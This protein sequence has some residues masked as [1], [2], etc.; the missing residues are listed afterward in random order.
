MGVPLRIRQSLSISLAVFAAVEVIM[1][2]H[3]LL[4]GPV[5]TQSGPVALTGLSL[6][7]TFATAIIAA[8]AALWMIEPMQ[9]PV[10]RLR[11]ASISTV[12]AYAAVL[13]GLVPLLTPFLLPNFLF[14]HDGG[15][16]QTYAYLFDRAVHQGQL[17]VRWVEGLGYGRGQPLFNYYQVGFYYLV[18]L[19]HLLGPRLSISVK[20]AIAAVWAAGTC[21]T[22]LWLRPLGRL[23]GLL[24]AAV[25]AW[26]PYLMVDG[27]VRTAYPEL[28]AVCLIPAVFW[29]LDR[30][31]RTGR[32]LFVGALALAIALLIISHLPA[33]LIVA[34]ICGAY[35]LARSV[36]RPVNMRHSLLTVMAVGVGIGLSAFYTLPSILE[37]DAVRIRG[38]TNN[39]LDFH[40]HFVRP[41]AWLDWAWGYAP[42][43]SGEA[44]QISTQI[45]IV[46]WIVVAAAAVAGVS[47]SS[48]RDPKR[49]AL[50]GWLAVVVYALFMM[51]AASVGIWNRIAPLAF[52]QFPWRFL[53]VPTVAC[54]AL[55]A[56]VLTFVPNRT[57]QALIVICA[58][59]LQWS[60]T[61]TYWGQAW[62]RERAAIA[63]DGPG[64]WISRN[65]S[66]WGFREAAYDPKG[67]TRTP[68]M[69]TERWT[70]VGGRSDV[71]PLLLT[72]TRV[73]L[74]V[75][76]SE[77]TAV[78][79]RSPFF[80]GW[81]LSLDG[82]RV[83]PRLQPDT[84]YM[85]VDV[86]PGSHRVDA[87][88]GNTRLRTTANRV[89][90]ASLLLWLGIVGW[91]L[92]GDARSSSRPFETL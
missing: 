23:P 14:A 28:M 10:N 7:T 41:A 74:R 66:M 32:P 53:M 91:S 27:Y 69:A 13:A 43:A 44:G 57:T 40:R 45:G 65:A 59:A 4:V 85:E 60:V 42:S 80:P 38:L 58:V 77:P 68:P 67:V 64:W 11:I 31:L 89:S 81:Q 46:Q 71:T 75:A 88:F 9:S 73:E 79:V 26:S 76:A 12:F 72:D 56:L 63:I 1:A 29:S 84:A 5:A 24:A 61:Q 36:V 47:V 17:P 33:A 8:G 83:T 34:P 20:L 62:V 18:E 52:I 16:H 35:L 3:V 50:V 49:L 55:A 86:P 78:I 19:I 82:R 37:L 54:S 70:T 87:R 2:V 92:F 6:T 21:F 90:A 39:Y 15:A 22:Y 48:P 25:F 51:T 30:L